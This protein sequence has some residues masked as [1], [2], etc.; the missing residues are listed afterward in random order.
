[1]DKEK[2]T[3]KELTVEELKQASGWETHHVMQYCKK[4]GKDTPF[5]MYSSTKGICTVCATPIN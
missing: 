3:A 5:L 4:C 1:M 2:N